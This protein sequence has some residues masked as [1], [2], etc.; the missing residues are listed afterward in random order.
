[1]IAKLRRLP[2]PMLR[3]NEQSILSL[4][5]ARSHLRAKEGEHAKR[6]DTILLNEHLKQG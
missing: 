5:I 3:T 6:L 4:Y 1:M 2:L